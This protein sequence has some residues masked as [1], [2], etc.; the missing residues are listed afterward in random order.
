MVLREILQN[1]AKI[2]RQFFQYE[3]AQFPQRVISVIPKEGKC[4]A[5]F[6]LFYRKSLKEAWERN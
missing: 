3:E 4:S 5:L 1:I 6:S 2:L